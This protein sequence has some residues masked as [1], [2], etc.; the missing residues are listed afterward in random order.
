MLRTTTATPTSWGSTPDA[1]KRDGMRIQRGPH[2]VFVPDD[3]LLSLA[4]SI[5][6]HL[7]N[8]RKDHQ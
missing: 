3:E 5:A 2:F 6:D 1:L 7:A 8:L 4:N